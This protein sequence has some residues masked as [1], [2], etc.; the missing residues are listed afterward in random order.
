MQN[1]KFL[2][3]CFYSPTA[4]V[5]KPT[6]C[7]WLFVH[8]TPTPTSSTPTCTTRTPTAAT[9]TTTTV[10]SFLRLGLCRHVLPH[11][12]PLG[13]VRQHRLFFLCNHRSFDDGICLGF[14]CIRP[15]VVWHHS[16]WQR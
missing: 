13:R 4:K 14:G 12:T 2:S 7:L 3:K 6:S 10:G 9:T 15:S 1:M 5:P 11:P 16:M 8:C